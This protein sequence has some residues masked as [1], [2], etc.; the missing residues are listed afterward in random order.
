MININWQY[1]LQNKNMR[2]LWE[3]AISFGLIHI[4]V[5]LYTA[6]QD[7]PLKFQYLRKSDQCQIGYVR[8]CKDSGEEVPWGDIVKGYQYQKGDYV[9]LHDEDFRSADAKKSEVIEIEDFVDEAEIDQI[10]YDKPYYIGPAHKSDKVYNLL[11][12]ALKKTGKVGIGRF[13]LRTKEQL[14]ALKA[15]KDILVLNVLRF[16]DQIKK[17][18][19]EMLPEHSELSERELILAMKLIDKLS[20]HFKPEK[21]H[22]TYTEKLEEI[23]EAK[24]KGKKPKITKY[25]K[26]K[27]TTVP[28]L[29][30]TL[31]ASL[32]KTHIARKK[33]KQ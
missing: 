20:G 21:Y 27:D 11:L 24:A 23:I 3:G 14:V 9:I 2:A 31:K 33:V 1:K 19:G 30:A 7:R 15:E 8:V 25:E 22:D 4:P 13:V 16:N 12:E 28:D 29:M 6:S 10:Y 26:A 18:A 32:E 17:P 5:K